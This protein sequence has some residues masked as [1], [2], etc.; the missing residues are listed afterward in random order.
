VTAGTTDVERNLEE[1][2]RKRVAAHAIHD[3]GTAV[4]SKTKPSRRSGDRW[5]AL[6][7]FVDVIAPRLTLVERAVWL[8]MFRYARNGVCDTSER[9]IAT[10]ARIDKA[11]AG[12][13]LRRLVEM[14]LVWPVFKSSTKGTSSRYGLHPRPASCLPAVVAADDARRKE[15]R[16]RREERG[17]DRRGRR[18]RAKSTG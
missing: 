13:A 17:G 4:V 9:A 3:D 8:V 1:H 11:S 2:R 14:G 15:A 7:T 6:N 10:Q 5:A 18:R 12:K 16:E